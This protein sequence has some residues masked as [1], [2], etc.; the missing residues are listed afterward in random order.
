M[1]PTLTISSATVGDFVQG[2]MI[3]ATVHLFNDEGGRLAQKESYWDAF[4]DKW[5][6]RVDQITGAADNAVD[7]WIEQDNPLMGTL[8]AT[9]TSDNI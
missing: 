2:A 3:A 6:E 9:L 8:A 4:A 7:Y 5:N 1:T